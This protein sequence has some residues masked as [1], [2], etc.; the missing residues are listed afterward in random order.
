MAGRSFNQSIT[1]AFL[2]HS[3]V[4]HQNLLLLCLATLRARSSRV[5]HPPIATSQK[6][7]T[8]LTDPDDREYR[9][10]LTSHLRHH[11]DSHG[12]GLAEARQ[13]CWL[14]RAGHHGWALCRLWRTTVRLRYWV[15]IPTPRHASSTS[16][17]VLHYDL[18]PNPT[19][20]PTD[21]I[22]DH[23]Y[24][25]S[26]ATRTGRSLNFDGRIATTTPRTKP[27][28]EAER[29]TLGYLGALITN[30][31]VQGY[32]R[33]TCNARIQR[34]IWNHLCRQQDRRQGNLR[35]AVSNH[36]RDLECWVCCWS[37][38]GRAGWRHSRAT[39]HPTHFSRSF[40]YWCYLPG[41]CT[42]DSHDACGEVGVGTLVGSNSGR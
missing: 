2:Q 30:K 18:P 1:A 27:R 7:S 31:V 32:Q 14:F 37:S 15:S 29:A 10:G 40:L 20:V 17:F 11:G 36:R 41:L 42:S 38:S 6:P 34:P 8:A 26:N 33:Y 22:D 35:R 24:L 25:P 9:P 3:T 28:I 16:R 13:C 39:L 5:R 19:I 4:R 12:H 23:D 21:C